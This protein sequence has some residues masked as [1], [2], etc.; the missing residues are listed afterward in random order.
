[1]DVHICEE[2]MEVYHVHFVFIL[3]CAIISSK[4]KMI[5]RSC[6]ITY[7]VG[8]KLMSKWKKSIVSKKKYIQIFYVFIKLTQLRMY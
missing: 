2:I 5:W 3:F 7:L 4:Q 1:M 8:L 6:N